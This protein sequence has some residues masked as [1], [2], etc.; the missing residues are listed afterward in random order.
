VSTAAQKKDRADLLAEV[1]K[2]IDADRQNSQKWKPLY[3]WFSQRFST[4]VK[5][6]DV[7][8]KLLTEDKQLSNRLEKELPQLNPKYI[9]LTALKGVDLDAVR[10]HLRQADLPEAHAALILQGQAPVELQFY[11]TQDTVMTALAAAF[12]ELPPVSTAR[13]GS[14]TAGGGVAAATGVVPKATVVVPLAIDERIHRMVELAILSTPAVILV[15]PPGTGKTQLLREVLQ[16]I[17][18]DPAAFGFV[19][20]VFNSPK[21]TTPEESWTTRELVG[22]ETVDEKQRLRFRPGQLLD[23]IAE[24]RWL[25]LDEA[26]RADMD[27]IF[28][29]VLTWLSTTR[30]DETVELGRVSTDLDAPQV[31]LGW[32]EEPESRV[33]RFDVLEADDPEGDPVRFLAGS[34]WRLLGTYNALDALRVFRFGEALGRRFARVPIPSPDPD[35]FETALGEQVTDLEGFEDQVVQAVA[36]LYRAHNADAA[37]ELGPA[38]FVKI[39]DYVRS[40]IAAGTGVDANFVRELT[41]EAYVVGVGTWLARLEPP[42]LEALGSRIQNDDVLTQADWEWLTPL[43]PALG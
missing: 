42:D 36:G 33:E 5:R 34:E 26:N 32:S 22:G 27:K 20:T 38:L 2:A 43:L 35:A 31:T 12:P 1:Q 9:V 25:V 29:P 37:T 3:E 4:A 24:N 21:W 13:P 41:A 28:G 8:G 15:G 30:P 39:P 7:A 10:R 11:T 16:K 40:G 18:A 23:A 14:A 17:E 19:S 6:G